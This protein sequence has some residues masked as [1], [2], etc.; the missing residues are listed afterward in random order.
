MEE[1]AAVTGVD[2]WFLAEMGKIVDLGWPGLREWLLGL[3][4]PTWTGGA[5]VAQRLGFSD[6]QLAYVFADRVDRREAL[7]QTVALRPKAPR[8]KAPNGDRRR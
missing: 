4:C 5:G 1:V 8:L 6:A 3:S 2:P 7:R